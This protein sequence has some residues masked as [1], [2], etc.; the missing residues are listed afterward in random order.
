MWCHLHMLVSHVIY[1]IIECSIVPCTGTRFVLHI[2]LDASP[3]FGCFAILYSA[4][5]ESM[6]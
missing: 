2:N 3:T 6:A 4:L 5:T 1:A